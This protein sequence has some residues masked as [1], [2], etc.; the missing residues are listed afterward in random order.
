MWNKIPPQH[1]ICPS[2]LASR[3]CLSHRTR[4]STFSFPAFGHGAPPHKWLISQGERLSEVY[5]CGLFTLMRIA[6]SLCPL[7]PVSPVLRGRALKEAT[8][9]SVNTHDANGYQATTSDRCFYKYLVYQVLSGMSV[10]RGTLCLM[11]LLTALEDER[12]PVWD[13]GCRAS[14]DGRG[15]SIR[16]AWN[17]ESTIHS[18]SRAGCALGHLVSESTDARAPF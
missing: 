6:F 16:L 3:A 17:N 13:V 18:T 12:M 1:S 15:D 11:T 7:H 10:S 14:T 2:S 5:P 8:R 9:A 4:A